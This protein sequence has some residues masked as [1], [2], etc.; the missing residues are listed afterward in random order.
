MSKIYKE[1]S[2]WWFINGGAIHGLWKNR[3][4]K[5]IKDISI[6]LPK[7]AWDEARREPSERIERAISYIKQHTV[8]A[9]NFDNEIISILEG[10]E[11]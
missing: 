5:A 7:I 9:T 1:F 10:C 3:S 11:K 6:T 2:D 4:Y 8:I